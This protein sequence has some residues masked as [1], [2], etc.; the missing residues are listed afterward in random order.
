MTYFG[1]CGE[2]THI[3]R[4]KCGEWVFSVRRISGV[5]CLG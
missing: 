2:Y 1:R 3:L 5:V 4:D